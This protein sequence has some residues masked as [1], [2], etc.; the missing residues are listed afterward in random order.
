MTLN[1]TTELLLLM[2]PQGQKKELQRLYDQLQIIKLLYPTRWLR[3][4][5]QKAPLMSTSE[6]VLFNRALSICNKAEKDV[7]NYIIMTM[8]T[9]PVIPFPF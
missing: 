4:N 6:L 5:T 8:K 1:L 3:I 9:S 7:Y 2:L